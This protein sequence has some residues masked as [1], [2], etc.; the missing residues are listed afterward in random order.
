MAVFVGI[1]IANGMDVSSPHLAH[2]ILVKFH[3]P[4]PDTD[5][6]SPLAAYDG[7]ITGRC[8]RSEVQ[9]VQIASSQNPSVILV[10]LA[11]DSRIAYAEQN[12][13]VWANFVPNDPQYAFQWNLQATAKGGINVEPAWDIH[14]GDPNVIVA[15][16]DTGIA[17]EDFEGFRQAPDLAGTRFVPGYD[18]IED[19]AHPNDD[20]GHGTHVAGTIAQSTHN[21][22]GVAGIAFGC[23]LMP[24]KVL[25]ANG[26]GDHFTIA[27]GI[28]Y[29]VDH[30]AR[31]INLSLGAPGDSRTLREA[32]A[33]AYER[34]VTV[35]CSA[36]NEFLL[37][38]PI[39]YPAA[40]NDFCLAV[41]AS[42]LRRTRAVYSGTGTFVDLVAPG[43]DMFSDDNGDSYGDGILQQ[44]FQL[45]PRDF[46]LWFFQGTSMAAPHVSGAAALLLSKG[47]RTPDAIRSALEQSAVDLG[48][49]G[50]DDDFGWGLL[51]LGTAMAQSS[52]SVQPEPG[53]VVTATRP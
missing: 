13:V 37:G 16:L 28:Y 38:N 25:D 14:T 44:T 9:R 22:L 39:I 33:Y 12:Y 52:I 19:D 36:G 48:P 4:C 40:Y 1:T 17:Y 18:F 35:V 45:D 43:G 5:P 6:T 26:L 24:V 21:D 31:V 51:D 23:S 7:K 32:M 20:H 47:L 10:S 15:V 50:V 3:S 53:I 41:G 11:N 42:T 49:E 29:A 2:E 27:R 34:D 30:G 46:S 8:E